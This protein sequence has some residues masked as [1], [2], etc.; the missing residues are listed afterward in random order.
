MLHYIQGF[1][2]GQGVFFTTLKVVLIIPPMNKLTYNTNIVRIY[3]S[4]VNLHK[5][6]IPNNSTPKVALASIL[7]DVINSFIS[8]NSLLNIEY[9]L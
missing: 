2:F 1:L 4:I 3:S 6:S 8:I 9:N 5:I 7:A